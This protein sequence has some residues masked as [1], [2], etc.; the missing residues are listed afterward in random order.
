MH[1]LKFNYVQ[2]YSIYIVSYAS[3]EHPRD[4]QKQLG[5]SNKNNLDTIRTPGYLHIDKPAEKI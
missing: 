5:N 4:K 3:M 2:A 1:M